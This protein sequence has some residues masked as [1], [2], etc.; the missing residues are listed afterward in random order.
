MRQHVHPDPN[1]YEVHSRTDTTT[2]SLALR[3][4][5]DA[6]ASTFTHFQDL[7]TEYGSGCGTW[8]PITRG[9]SMFGQFF[10]RDGYSSIAPT[11]ASSPSPL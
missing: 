11:S 4:A 5:V 8:L 10:R 3:D 6:P 7:P 1:T 2:P 9:T